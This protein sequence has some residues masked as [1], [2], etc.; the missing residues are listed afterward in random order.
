MSTAIVRMS[1]Q[2]TQRT[3]AVGVVRWEKI[4][5]TVEHVATRVQRVRPVKTG[6]AFS[7]VLRTKCFATNPVWRLRMTLPIVVDVGS[8]AHADKFVQLARAR[9]RVRGPTSSALVVAWT[10]QPIENIAAAVA[11][12][13]L[14]INDARMACASLIA[15]KGR[16]FV[17]MAAS[18]PSMTPYTAVNV[19]IGVSKA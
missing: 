3:V 13:V 17:T 18:I 6:A 11:F 12:N 8:V 9:T 2:T 5:I 16:S 4:P 19:I 15:M 7:I 10:P 1:A 14:R